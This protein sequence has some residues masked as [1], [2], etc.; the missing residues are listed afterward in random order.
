M[1]IEDYEGKQK[2]IKETDLLMEGMLI[3]KGRQSGSDSRDAL[4]KYA[5]A[6]KKK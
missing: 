2:E 6:I 3:E 1:K 5:D 4:Q